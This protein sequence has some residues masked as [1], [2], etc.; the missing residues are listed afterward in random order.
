M[1]PRIGKTVGL[2]LARRQTF[3]SP[4]I[5]GISWLTENV[6]V[7]QEGF[8]STELESRLQDIWIFMGRG[9]NGL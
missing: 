6:F 4:K 3:W 1:L 5:W 2:L 7:S 9:T 8:C